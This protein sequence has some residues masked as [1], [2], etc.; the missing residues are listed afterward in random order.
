MI[1]FSFL[2]TQLCILKETGNILFSSY[3]NSVSE[4]FSDTDSTV[5]LE[6]EESDTQLPNHSIKYRLLGPMRDSLWFLQNWSFGTKVS[7]CLSG[8]A[9]VETLVLKRKKHGHLQ[10]CPH[11]CQTERFKK[12]GN[13]QLCRVRQQ[14]Q[15]RSRLKIDNGISQLECLCQSNPHGIGRMVFGPGNSCFSQEE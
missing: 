1:F 5:F 10:Y 7:S 9:V 3:S 4:G 8:G 13:A 2:R 15:V 14:G 11:I 6:I 12:E